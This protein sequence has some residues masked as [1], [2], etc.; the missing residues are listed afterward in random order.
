MSA[1]ERERRCDD[2][3]VSSE[4]PDEPE[5]PCH[6]AAHMVPFDAPPEWRDNRRL[7]RLAGG[8]FVAGAALGLVT[9]ELVADAAIRQ[10]RDRGT[11]QYTPI[12][13]FSTPVSALV[14]LGTLAGLV[15]VILATWRLATAHQ[16][17]GRPGS[18]WGPGWAIAGRLIPLASVVLPALQLGELWRGSEPG[19]AHGDP[20]W[21]DRSTSLATVALVIGNVVTATLGALIV[22]DLMVA[23]FDVVLRDTV[24]DGSVRR[25]LALE[26]AIVESVDRSRPWRLTAGVLGL[27]IALLTAWMLARIADRQQRLYE[28]NPALPRPVSA[29]APPPPGF[30]PDPWAR[31][32]YRWWN[33][34][35][36]G[37][38]VWTGSAMAED[39]APVTPPPPPT[40][41]PGPPSPPTLPS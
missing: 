38:A 1:N 13:G 7:A 15:L 17:L 30:Y 39:P 29:V 31:A 4:A 24:D 14:G 19:T 6:T 18:R 41:P 33:G 34:R 40:P 23:S 22:V 3:A 20:A 16:Q 11:I 37:T 8:V 32:M 25:S 26:Q 21:K 28:A 9:S 5:R 36:W 10:V 2:W 12:V 35:G 27:A